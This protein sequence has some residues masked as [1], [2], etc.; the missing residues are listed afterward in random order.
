MDDNLLAPG[1]ER[2]DRCM[3]PQ[4]LDAIAMLVWVVSICWLGSRE[5]AD[6]IEINKH[7]CTA[8]DYTVRVKGL[9]QTDDVPGLHRSAQT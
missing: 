9:P 1:V 5:R 2:A 4:V 7:I 3:I 8:A 6:S